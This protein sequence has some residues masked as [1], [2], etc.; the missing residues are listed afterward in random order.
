MNPKTIITI[1]RQYGSGGREIGEKLASLLQIPFYD[2]ELLTLAAQKSGMSEEVFQNYDEK[3]TN[4]LL[5]SLSMG[6]Y[7][8]GDN[9]AAYIN[10]PINH[11]VFLAQFDAIKSIAQ[12]GGCV[13]VGRCADYALQDYPHLVNVF[14]HADLKKRVQRI[15]ERHHVSAKEA[16]ELITKTDK[17]RANYYNFYAN[18]KWGSVD[19][20]HLAIDSSAVGIDH[21]VQMIADFA[22]IKEPDEK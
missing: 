5:Y 12:K 17:R 3:P 16:E 6:T 21:T 8:M 13:I 20:Y 2:K 1:G 15:M 22:A 9:G 7:A 4:S 14:I 11:K 19:T 18:K 10:L